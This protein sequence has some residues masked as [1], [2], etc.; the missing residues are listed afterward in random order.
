MGEGDD[1]I[2]VNFNGGKFTGDIDFGDSLN[3][4]D[5]LILDVAASTTL[6]FEGAI[7]NLEY[8]N[9][10]CPGTAIV[11]DVM[12]DGSTVDIEEGQLLV[13]GHLNV[14]AGDVTIHDQALL[15]FEVGDIVTV[16]E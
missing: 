4:N 5:R 10:R 6:L 1:T 12:F 15:A 7:S 9:K 14:G 16:S 13:T 8:M 2:T 11:G 3:D